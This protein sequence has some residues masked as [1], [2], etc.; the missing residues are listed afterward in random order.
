MQDYH[1]DSSKNLEIRNYIQNKYV[2]SIVKLS[3]TPK[4]NDI[5]DGV[6]GS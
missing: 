1:F 4:W 3:K 2:F 5:L 6:S